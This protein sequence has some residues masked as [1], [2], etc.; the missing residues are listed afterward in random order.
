M[1]FKLLE[2]Q[3]EFLENIQLKHALN[4]ESLFKRAVTRKDFADFYGLDALSPYFEGKAQLPANMSEE[5]KAKLKGLLLRRNKLVWEIANYYAQNMRKAIVGELGT[6]AWE[7]PDEESKKQK[8][9]A[10]GLKSRSAIYD[11][12]AKNFTP[13]QMIACFQALDWSSAYGGPPWE[14]IA[15]LYKELVQQIKLLKSYIGS[16]DVIRWHMDG[17]FR[18]RLGS[19]IVLIDRIHQAEHNTG[20]LFTHFNDGISDWIGEALNEKAIPSSVQKIKEKASPDVSEMLGEVYQNEPYADEMEV[21]S[22]IAEVQM[23]RLSR[24]NLEKLEIKHEKTLGRLQ[25]ELA[26]GFINKNE[27][28]TELRMAKENYEYELK[29]NAPGSRGALTALTHS[30]AVSLNYILAYVLKQKNPELLQTFLED[31]RYNINL[32]TM[33]PAMFKQIAYMG[34]TGARSAITTALSENARSALYDNAYNPGTLAIIYSMFNNMGMRQLAQVANLKY[35][36]NLFKINGY[37]MSKFVPVEE[38][39][40]KDPY[41]WQYFAGQE[42]DKQLEMFASRRTQRL[43]KFS[44]LF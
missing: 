37:D 11:M 32:W 23:S 40:K 12:G 2:A 26:S 18:Q 19:L 28:Q 15:V 25:K 41:D 38:R 9:Q 22:Q 36:L 24:K 13:E 4:I 14:N 43:E 42:G 3:I 27:Y 10:V 34:G 33:E 8:L 17:T 5:H 16:H 31:N 39:M 30:G 7:W 44:G 29:N 1:I 20:S 35:F 6:S 21:G